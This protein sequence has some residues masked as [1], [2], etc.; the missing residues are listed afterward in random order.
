MPVKRSFTDMPVG[1]DLRVRP[2]RFGICVGADLRVRP[3]SIKNDKMQNVRIH[4]AYL[5]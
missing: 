4:H 5:G 2:Q 1:A 3:N